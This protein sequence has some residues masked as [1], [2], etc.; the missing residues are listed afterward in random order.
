[1]AADRS[2]NCASGRDGWGEHSCSRSAMASN[3]QPSNWEAVPCAG[4]RC[5]KF[6]HSNIVLAQRFSNGCHLALSEEFSIPGRKSFPW[7][8]SCGWKNL[9]FLL[10]VCS[11]HKKLHSEVGLDGNVYSKQRQA[12]LAAVTDT[13]VLEESVWFIIVYGFFI[14]GDVK[15]LQGEELTVFGFARGK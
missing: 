9:K 1:M 14:V 4:L 7:R 8:K 10:F 5:N 6:F 3:T 15:F 11:T 13:D 2:L 12:A